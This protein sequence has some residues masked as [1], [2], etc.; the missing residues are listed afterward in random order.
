LLYLE[1]DRMDW[2]QRLIHLQGAGTKSG[3]RRSIPLNATARAALVSRAA[4]RAAQCPASRWVFCHEQGRRLQDVKNSFNTACRRAGI[5]DF[6][7]H[8]LRHTCAA[9][10]I[11]AGV[12]LAEIRDLLGHASIEMTERYAHLAPENIRAAVAVLEKASRCCHAGILPSEEEMPQPFEK[13]GAPGGT[14]TRD[15]RLRR[16]TLYPTEL[17]AR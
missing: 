3:K 14:R 4:F 8:D 11:Q 15:L 7:F 5:V 17:R 12:P 16:P 13:T 1:W 6:H 9:W 2:S 10:M